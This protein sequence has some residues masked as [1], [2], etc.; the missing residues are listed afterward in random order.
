MPYKTY[1]EQNMKK[2]RSA[3]SAWLLFLALPFMVLS[4][5]RADALGRQ[6]KIPQYDAAAVIKLIVVRVLDQDGRPVKN[7]TKENFALSDNG[8]T[9]TITEF[10]VH[11]L[12]EGDSP[13]PRSDPSAEASR[14]A[15]TMPRQFL[16]FLD[17]QG[18]DINGL[19][20]AKSA[21][22]HFVNTQLLPGDS[23]GIIGFR[24]MSG[25]FIQEYLTTDHEKIVAAIKKAKEVRGSP[26]FASGAGGD[27]M[28][29]E[30]GPPKNHSGQRMNESDLNASKS[31]N[32]AP[33][34]GQRSEI[35]VPGSRA[36]Q[37]RDFF[38]RL[39][40]LAEA[41]KHI[42]GNKN[43]VMFSGRSMAAG[44][45]GAMGKLFAAAS[46]PVYTVNTKN[47]IEQGIIHL[48]IKKKHIWENH[49]LKELSNTSGGRYFADIEDTEGI[50]EEIQMLT[51]NYYVLGYYVKE[52]WDGKYHTIKVKLDRPELTVLA[53]DG[54][55]NPKPFARMSEYEKQLHLADLLFGEK[56]MAAAVPLPLEPLLV[57]NREGINVVLLAS[58]PVRDSAGVP[59]EHAEIYAAVKKE[60]GEMVMI[61][62]G[63]ADLTPH[64]EEDLLLY[65]TADLPP[66]EYECRVV[67]R[68]LETGEANVG[69]VRFSAP[70]KDLSPAVLSS[71]LLFTEG[72]QSRILRLQEGKKGGK[73]GNALGEIYRLSPKGHCLVVRELPQG[74]RELLAVLPI[75]SS[76]PASPGES[77]ETTPELR[78]TVRLRFTQNNE[79]V[80]LP[81]EILDIRSADEGTDIAVLKIGLGD[82]RAGSYELEITA[83]F[84]DLRCR[85]V[86]RNL[87]LH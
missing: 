65:V 68:G 26:A 66:G 78:L 32:F 28:E 81:S 42:E 19:D 76:L 11:T 39:A 5:G 59:P 14:P 87:T 67:S 58:L 60:G 2:H 43:L 40:D 45:A 23:V 86:T 27:T 72:S 17:I 70:D 56:A 63:E 3:P 73:A 75:A 83:E 12:D 29:R 55:F 24:P 10:E 77:V 54:Y 20:N 41:L 6:D 38:A 44:V 80:I 51:G 64:A 8:K 31:M 85:P 22:L 62:R 35:I 9:M 1:Q 30:A 49:P 53:Q 25:F 50:A 15:G 48:R 13:A 71:P 82:L 74:T 18:S 79:T 21:A 61:A 84:G 52:N 16:L 47:W 36:Q 7:L 69:S 33:F 37:H 34:D 46:T 57:S 4:A